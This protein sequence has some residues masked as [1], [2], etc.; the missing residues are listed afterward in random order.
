MSAQCPVCP[1]AAWLA[2]YEYTP[3]PP[4]SATASFV[5]C[6][7]FVVCS[8]MDREKLEQHLQEAERNIAQSTMHVVEQHGL[9]MRL[10]RDGRDTADA[11][12]LLE[13]FEESREL[14]LTDRDRLRR[15]LAEYPATPEV[16]RVEGS[17]SAPEDGTPGEGHGDPGTPGGGSQSC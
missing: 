15:E 4:R 10:E 1:K 16:P 2:I 9:V 17:P 11:R 14:Y 8:L 7:L 5:L 6:P 3:L 13:L 12:R